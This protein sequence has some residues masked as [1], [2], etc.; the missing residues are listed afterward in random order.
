MTGRSP[1]DL[2]DRNTKVIQVCLT[3]TRLSRFKAGQKSEHKTVS[4]WLRA[5]IKSSDGLLR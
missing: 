1:K 4:V 5:H 2:A 3:E